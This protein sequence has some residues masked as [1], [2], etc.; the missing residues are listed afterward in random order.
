M[1]VERVLWQGHHQL[2]ERDRAKQGRIHGKTV[3]DG[4]AG[5]VMQKPLGIQKCDLPTYGRTDVPTYRHGKVS[6]TKSIRAEF[7]LSMD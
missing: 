4:W 7:E 6:A 1:N 3:A 2:F 5:A